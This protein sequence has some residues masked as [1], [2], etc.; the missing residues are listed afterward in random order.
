MSRKDVTDQRRER[1]VYCGEFTAHF[2]GTCVEHRYLVERDGERLYS[3]V[4][5]G[6]AYVGV[7]S[8]L[9]AQSR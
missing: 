1:C 3:D 4:L 9:D 8:P 5:D 7:K 6:S 2:T